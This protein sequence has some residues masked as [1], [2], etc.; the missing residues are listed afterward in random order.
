MIKNVRHPDPD[1]R[2]EEVE[3]GE[4]VGLEGVHALVRVEGLGF[5]I[6]GLGLGDWG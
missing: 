2:N 6:W 5:R 1:L 4:G 3:E